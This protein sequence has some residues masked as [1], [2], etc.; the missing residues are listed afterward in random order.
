[1]DTKCPKCN[2]RFRFE[3]DAWQNPEAICPSCGN[4]FYVATTVLA[5]AKHQIFQPEQRDS[6]ER[7]T[8]AYYRETEAYERNEQPI[9]QMK[10]GQYALTG[11]K[12]AP[13]MVF[14]RGDFSSKFM[15]SEP[16]KSPPPEAIGQPIS[17]PVFEKKIEDMGVK[18]QKVLEDKGDQIPL[19]P[20][21]TD[22][23]FS[24]SPSEPAISKE[25]ASVSQSDFL[26]GLP[27]DEFFIGVDKVTEVPKEKPSGLDLSFDD[28]FGTDQGQMKQQLGEGERKTPSGE[29]DLDAVI[30]DDSG[31]EP[32]LPWVEPKQ[33]Q[34]GGEVK[35]SE[36]SSGE[37]FEIDLKGL[38]TVS[39][40]VEEISGEEKPVF[41]GLDIDTSGMTPDA[42]K[43]DLDRGAYP[44]PTEASGQMPKVTPSIKKTTNIAGIIK[45]I[46]LGILL[47]VL[48][49]VI[50]GQTN[51]G[52][53]GINLLFH[54]SN[55]KTLVETNHENVTRV[56]DRDTK[57]SYQEKI[58][59]LEKE[60][61]ENPDNSDLKI[62]LL[63]ALL[64]FR[65]R[66]PH[67]F[68]S[69]VR[70]QGLLN[71]MR[72]SVQLSGA[73]AEKIKVMELVNQ[74]KW[75]EAKTALDAMV[76][77]SAQ[78]AEILYF[79][80]K[81][82]LGAGKPEEAQ[83]YFEL[84]LM[85]NPDMT[86]ARFFL[87]QS[88]F[89]QKNMAKGKTILEEILAREP[90]HLGAKVALADIAL[91]SREYDTAT[92][93]ATE[94]IAKANATTKKDDL[95]KAHFI[96]AKVMEAKGARD[97]RIREL[98]TALSI[99]PDDE[100][101][102][103]EM[104]KLLMEDKKPEEA[105][106]VL[107]PCRQKGC[108]SEDF[109]AIYAEAALAMAKEELAETIFKEA[110]QRYPES[111]R[112]ALIRGKWYLENQRT[113]AAIDT[114]T[115]A[116]KIDSRNAHLYVLLAEALIQAGKPSE[117][118]LRLKQGLDAGAQMVPILESLSKTYIKQR[119]YIMAEETLRKLVSIDR[120]N[121][122]ALEQLGLVVAEL[123]R[124]GE[125][126]FILEPLE[127]K[128]ALSREGRLG[129]AKAYLKAKEPSKAV[130]L[131]AK[132]Y[133]EWSEDME[134]ATEYAHALIEADNVD[135][136]REILK[137]ITETNVSYGPG[138]FYLGRFYRK[139]GDKAKASE[140]FMRAVRLQPSNTKFRLEFASMLIEMG[141]PEN[142][143]DAKQQLDLVIVSYETGET[144]AEEKDASAYLMRGK[145]LFKMQNFQAALKDYETALALAPSNMDLLV[146]SGKTLW[147]LARYNDAESYFRQ[148]LTRDQQHPEANYY[149]GRILL[150]TNQIQAAKVHLERAVAQDPK[151]FPEALR[152]LGLILKEQGLTQ[153][154]RQRFQ[155]Y[156]Q[157]MPK[158][159]PEVEE[160]K[161]IL[162]RLR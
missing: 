63:E 74:G 141:S 18:E 123:N 24:Q 152:Y 133:T 42:L 112:F 49:G 117:A 52:Y 46:S 8:E 144:T 64:K 138:Y 93:L 20:L 99:Y 70:L 71:Q 60:L 1:M 14:K 128:R 28:L 137:K 84:A 104:A 134:V 51:Y 158:S 94:I 19:S 10:C 79:Y 35:A 88:F 33:Q 87:A 11:D 67:A 106:E 16:K 17:K 43:I 59:R 69:D 145:I 3:G 41:T 83:R 30:K 142:L 126:K 105:L 65:E 89:A 45:A 68:A 151:M 91:E 34:M 15:G 13:D 131:L 56:F 149:L 124:L 116:L 156:L 9:G 110:T 111:S 66:Y 55:T 61:K 81:I 6:K 5:T 23:I 22:Y 76:I 38:E 153:L 154:A 140:A 97:D 40:V 150:R 95:F 115:D 58:L 107:N 54:K 50:L 101:I 37:H 147:E 148:V 130:D 120:T 32:V 160:V 25:Q 127:V 72:S 113:K 143:K 139:I 129:L 31:V 125:A 119:D 102:A 57:E 44:V 96:L 85:K 4:R 26:S 155:Q 118:I 108:S 29:L 86:S 114:L 39:P 80:G 103:L 21:K 82:A 78:D 92:K 121:V 157:L 62:E 2:A 53:F 12:V 98:K 136:A 90:D 7:R 109:Y 132:C 159:T 75:E 135:K 47:L 146:E 48:V 122:K 73:K 27:Q 100:K 36:V 161:G 162:A 77:A